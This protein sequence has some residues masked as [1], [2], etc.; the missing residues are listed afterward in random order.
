MKIKSNI[1]I[2]IL[3]SISLILSITIFS[4]SYFFPSTDKEVKGLTTVAFDPQP[5]VQITPELNISRFAPYVISSNDIPDTP[6]RV[7]IELWGKNGD[8]VTC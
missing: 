6:Q 4:F 5:T 3:V 8:G 2:Y 7:Y 1:R